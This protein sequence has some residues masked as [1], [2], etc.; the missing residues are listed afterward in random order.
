VG[1]SLVEI[2]ART[3]APFVE[4]YG[5]GELARVQESVERV[6]QRIGSGAVWNVN[7]TARGG[8]VAELLR[9]IVAYA[10]GA[11]VDCR[12][13]VMDGEADFFRLT[14]QLHNAIHGHGTDGLVLDGA[15]R[16][17][18]ERTAHTATADLLALVRPNDVVILHDPQTAGLCEPLHR[19]GAH[20][21]W[22]CHIG[23]DVPNAETRAA[24]DFLAPYVRCAAAC[25]FTRS[26]YIPEQLAH[27]RCVVVPP[28]IDPESAKNQFMSD[29]TARAILVQAGLVEGPPPE[30]G[31]AEYRQEDGSL[32][33]VRRAADV[34]RLGRAPSWETPLVVQVSRW[35]RLKDP[36]GVMRGFE[37]LSSAGSDASLVLAG[38]NVR[39]VAD[40]PE[41][42]AVFE[43]VVAAWRELP[44]GVRM[45]VELASLPMTDPQENAAM[46]NALQRH[47]AV[48][49][50]KSLEEGFGLTVAEA[51]WKGR[52]VVASRVG[53][54][55]DQI[56]HDVSGLLLDDPRDPE[57][58]ARALTR[59]LEDPALAR[60]LG[61][62]G[63]RR[64][65][66]L[67]INLRSLYAYTDLILEITAK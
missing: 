40:D 57:Q 19:H 30:G 18:Y 6:L 56:E 27:M 67:F 5:P 60:K 41:G 62:Q 37:L 51:M 35:D 25:V 11:G 50:Q 66:D 44:H 45:R 17:I 39:A 33:S 61:E 9:S 52:P 53:G 8:G 38:P 55:Q 21:I 24:W 16:A 10:R 48:V 47:A 14:K 13:V 58:L 22:R 3:L 63:Q 23:R 43:E 34:M 1:I 29:A 49:V 36:V 65:R 64:V 7:S 42:A 46:V 12:W 2:G 54:I 31:R 32:S 26:Q 28:T 4:L 59:V 15:A 20:V